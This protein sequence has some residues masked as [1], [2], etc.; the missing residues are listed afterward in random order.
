MALKFRCPSCEKKLAIP[1]KFAGK[2]IRC[3]KCQAA[4][5]TPKPRE[6]NPAAPPTAA[7]PTAEPPASEPTTVEP[8]PTQPSPV[9]P[10]SVAEDRTVPLATPDEVRRPEAAFDPPLEERFENSLH[11][12]SDDWSGDPPGSDAEPATT[13]DAAVFG[14]PSGGPD[15]SDLIR[16]SVAAAGVATASR[17]AEI[18][19]KLEELRIYEETVD[20]LYDDNRLVASRLQ[21]EEDDL[22]MTPMVD[23]TFLLLIFF[24]ITASFTIQ[25]SMPTQPPQEEAQAAAAALEPEEIEEEPVLVEIF[26][27]NSVAVEGKKVPLG[28]PLVD[29]LAR[30]RVT[31]RRTAVTIELEPAAT[32]GT[33]V[34]VQDAAIEAGMEEI[35]RERRQ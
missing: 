17:T 24:M 19:R 25:K 7:S 30:E 13:A 18:R 32:H 22:D 8:P 1:E 9:V 23:V 21:G 28:R 10:D 11:D 2:K 15:D 20:P 26:A 35:K 4:V 6:P 33:V 14:E 5:R 31:A 12:P 34:A 29:A 16:R 27:D 3:P